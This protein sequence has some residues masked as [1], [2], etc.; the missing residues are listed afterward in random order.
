MSNFIVIAFYTE[1]TPYQELIQTCLE[2]SLTALD[3]DYQLFR[4]ENLGSWI[5]NVAMKPRIISEALRMFP[6]QYRIICLDADSEVVSYPFLFDEIPDD[7]HI[8]YHTLNWNEWYGYNH[9]PPFMEVL[10]G[11]MWIN[12]THQTKIIVDEWC[13]RAQHTSIWEQKILG[14]VIQTHPEIKSYSLPLEYC[15]ISSLPDGRKPLIQTNPV[16]V[17]HQASRKYKKQIR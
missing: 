8:G 15:Y 14:D 6:K 16:I 4:K 10:S 17:H 13:Q 12:N 7:Y 3:I 5:K 11:T 2:P 9:H 1:D